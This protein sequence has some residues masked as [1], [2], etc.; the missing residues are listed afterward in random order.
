MEEKSKLMIRLTNITGQV[1][2]TE[3]INSFSG[4]FSQDIS[5]GNLPAGYYTLEIITVSGTINKKILVN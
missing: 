3:N 5:V 4:T 1:V 2:Y